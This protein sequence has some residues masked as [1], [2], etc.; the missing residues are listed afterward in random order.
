ML[1]EKDLVMEKLNESDRF[2]SIG[3]TA[4]LIGVSVSTVRRL[5]ER[6]DFPNTFKITESRIGLLESEVKQWMKET[7]EKGQ[8][9]NDN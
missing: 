1:L 3:V 2:I 9:A 6:S 8:A 4:E 5:I 7:Y